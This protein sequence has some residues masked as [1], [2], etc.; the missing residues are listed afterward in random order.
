MEY[1]SRQDRR[2]QLFIRAATNGNLQERDYLLNYTVA[3]FYNEMSLFIE[4][5]EKREAA[6]KEMHD[7]HR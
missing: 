3:E 7:K 4:E 6:L 2:H 1:H 5:T